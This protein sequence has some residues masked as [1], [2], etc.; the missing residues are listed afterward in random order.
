MDYGVPV[1]SGIDLKFILAGIILGA[2]IAAIVNFVLNRRKTLPIGAEGFYGGAAKGCGEPACLHSSPESASLV[3]IFMEKGSSTLPDFQEFIQIL[4]K[5]ACLQKDLMSPS[6]IVDATRNL[7]FSTLHDREPVAD[8]AARCFNKTIPQRDLEISLDT[9]NDRGSFLLKRLCVTAN[10][11]NSELQNVEGLFK[12]AW[13]QC[14]DIARS[15]CIAGTPTIVGERQPRQP[16]AFSP[17]SI[18]DLGKY[19][20]APW[21]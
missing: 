9:W 18:A 5:M 4:S 21:G 16:D 7:S 13:T 20:E 14:R 10:L 3:S 2:V 6:H 15:Q 19:S 11:N 17:E 1:R 12:T 8:T